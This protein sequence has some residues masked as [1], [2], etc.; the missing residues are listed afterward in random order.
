MQ[1]IHLGIVKKEEK[2]RSNWERYLLKR[3]RDLRLGPSL[4]A[5]FWSPRAA[6][7]VWAFKKVSLLK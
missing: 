3:P 4:V 1:F 6:F 5:A 7:S 2:K